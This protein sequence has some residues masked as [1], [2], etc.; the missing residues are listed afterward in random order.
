MELRHLRYFIAAGELE[1]FRKAAHHLN[2]AQPALSR[3]IQLLE[4]ELGYALFER[5]PRGVCLTEAGR[6]FL[7]DARAILDSVETASDQGRRIA[8]GE[9]GSLRLA[10]SESGSVQPV[11][12][13]IIAAFR[14]ARPLVELTVMGMDSIYQ[15]E[16]LRAGRLDCGFLYSATAGDKRFHGIEIHQQGVALALPARHPLARRASIRL[17]DLRTEPM[18]L[19]AR[20]FNQKFFDEVMAAFTAGG[21]TPQVVQHVS[22]GAIVLNL[23]AAGMGLGLVLED[24]PW[25][26]PKALVLRPISGFRVQFRLDLVWPRDNH[27]KVLAEFVECARRM[28]DQQPRSKAAENDSGRASI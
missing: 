5:L 19:M 24:M 6:S 28:V 20:S 12:S 11:V 7:D 8:R 2:L 3:Q 21:L 10:M 18:I 13:I 17:S 22:P 15:F 9:A 14:K 27:S 16:A 4:Q 26:I 1:N 23:V 25:K